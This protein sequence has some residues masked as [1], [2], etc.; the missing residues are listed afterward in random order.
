MKAKK[1]NTFTES[2][3]E[4]QLLEHEEPEHRGD[5]FSMAKAT[6]AALLATTQRRPADIAADLGTSGYV[7]R[8]WLGEDGFRRLMARDA[9]D[10][11]AFFAQIVGKIREGKTAPLPVD[12]PLSGLAETAISYEVVKRDTSADPDWLLAA[13]EQLESIKAAKAQAQRNRW[14]TK[15]ALK[16]KAQD[17]EIKLMQMA[18]EW[19]S[20]ELTVEA[21]LHFIRHRFHGELEKYLPDGA[22][23]ERELLAFLC[24]CSSKHRNTS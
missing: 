17:E 20:R 19:P 23:Q 8:N 24:G 4:W 1:E 22:G 18:G 15:R 7:V 14:A 11:G 6:A 3:I 21:A 5:G 9:R 16:I 13:A 12:E 10:T 2:F